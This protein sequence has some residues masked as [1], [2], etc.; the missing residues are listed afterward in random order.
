M[1]VCGVP[2]IGVRDFRAQDY[3][4]GIVSQVRAPIWHLSSVQSKTVLNIF[5][6]GRFLVFSVL[7]V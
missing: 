6:N 7:Q 4:F 2:T 5:T 1:C 3:I